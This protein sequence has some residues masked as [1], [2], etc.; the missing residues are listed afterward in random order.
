[1]WPALVALA[2]LAVLLV[3]M[4]DDA[5]GFFPE[6]FLEAGAVAFLALA[7]LLIV[8]VPSYRITGDALVALGLLAAFAAWTALSA[9]WSPQ[10]DEALVDFQRT[11]T[12]VG[13][14]ALALLAAG[15]GRWARLLPWA[16]L[17]VCV[18]VVGLGLVSRLQPDLVI[19][20]VAEVGGFRLSH[21]FTYW[22]AYGGM[23]ALGAILATG[24]AADAHAR[25]ALRALACG[26]AVPLAVAMYLSLSRGSWLALIAG[27]VALLV[28]TPFRVSAL[29]TGG[30]VGL[31]T[32]I[33]ITRLSGLDALVEDPRA[34]DGQE[35][36]GDAFTGFLV[37]LA[38][39]AAGA[40][41]ALGGVR[42]WPAMQDLAAR[43][44]GRA[45]AVAACVLVLGGGA[46]YVVAGSSI[47]GRS[48]DVMSDTTDWLD[49]QWD[50]F[51]STSSVGG[52]SGRERLTTSRGTRSD[53][54][55][56]ALDGFGAHPLRG[57][58]AAAFEWRWFQAREVNEDTREPHSLWLGT[59]GEL[60]LVGGLLL[61]GF[62][63]AF[64]VATWRGLRTPAGLRRGETAAVAAAG[65][66]W[67]AHSSVDWDWQMPAFTAT[68][69]VACAA[70]LPHG[71][72]RRRRARA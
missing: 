20:D 17:L 6:S 39:A 38:L 69:F 9:A 29:L 57:D 44:R 27:G 25:P 30:V 26:L 55:R 60:G 52:P 45:A 68:A 3:R 71:R 70:L 43:A 15:S 65:V 67:L 64:G 16:A 41:L 11:L 51:L 19:A 31:A 58:G 21:P 23:A 7:A 32:A 36:Q 13:L 50:D 14:F 56:V 72:S 10:P 22:N 40:Q 48:A 61:L 34:G 66:V 8:R 33:A 4:A 59:L 42:S 24:L 35:S 12:Y 37:V 28:L 47:E 46:A 54:Y 53:L 49:R 1:M 2:V 5:G 18:A 63:G 62:V